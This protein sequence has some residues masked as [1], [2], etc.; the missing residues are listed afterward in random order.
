[1]TAV[2]YALTIPD[3]FQVD[4]RLERKQYTYSDQKNDEDDLV[5]TKKM[6]SSIY[7]PIFFCRPDNNKRTIREWWGRASLHQYRRSKNV[8]T[9][10]WFVWCAKDTCIIYK[11]CLSLGGYKLSMY[12][13]V[14][15]G[16]IIMII[17]AFSQLI[18]QIICIDWEEQ[19]N[20]LFYIWVKIW[21]PTYIYLHF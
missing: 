2:C 8:S 7:I 18:F 15:G 5:E 16:D 6:K 19:V 13:Y 4:S 9:S 3:H 17:I 1:M 20:N 11:G 10:L 12:V 14:W 21:G